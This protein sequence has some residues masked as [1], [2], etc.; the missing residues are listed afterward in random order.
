MG[1]KPEPTSSAT[2]VDSNRDPS[3]SEGGVVLADF[4][5]STD[6]FV[7]N[8]DHP[9]PFLVVGQA[10]TPLEGFEERVTSSGTLVSD[11]SGALLDKV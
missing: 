11:L 8:L 2:I 7:H 6:G 9:E 5:G 10:N 4:L 1:M 3:D